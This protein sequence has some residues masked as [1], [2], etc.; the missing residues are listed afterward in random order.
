MSYTC[1]SCPLRTRDTDGSCHCGGD[2]DRR[3]PRHPGDSGLLH[4]WW[5][6]CPPPDWCPR[7][8]ENRESLLF[9]LVG[10]PGG[11]WKERRDWDRE[12]DAEA[13]RCREESR[14]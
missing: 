14:R 7:R 2:P 1:A 11:E 13:R 10:D 8:P 4:T 5:G 6:L 9:S 3:F 12:W